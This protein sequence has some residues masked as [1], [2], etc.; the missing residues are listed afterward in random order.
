MIR[1]RFG[2]VG[3]FAVAALVAAL[4]G[5]S[6]SGSSYLPTGTSLTPAPAGAAGSAA[7]LPPGAASTSS[8][9]AA[10]ADAALRSLAP[11]G[12]TTAL[13]AVPRAVS[14]QSPAAASLAPLATSSSHDLKVMTFNL[15]VATA[16][17]LWNTWDFRRGQVVERIRSFDPDLLG[18]QE[19]LNGME[20][21]L[22]QELP[23]YTFFGVG[24]NDGKHSGEFCGVFYKTSRFEKLAGGTFWLSNH[25]EKVGSKAWG[26]WFPRIV[27]WVELRPRE[28]GQ[29]FYWFNT[30]FA[31]F[32][33]RAR[34]E[35]AKLLQA[36]MT[37]ISTGLPCVL[38][39]DFN[40]NAGIDVAAYR[41]LTSS[42]NVTRLVDAFRAAHPARTRDEGTRHDFNGHKDGDRIDWILTSP[43]FQTVSCY[44]DRTRGLLGY[45]SDHFPVMATLRMTPAASPAAPPVYPVARTG[46]RVATAQ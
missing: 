8:P 34:A 14:G 21:Y 18:T 35:S 30:H 5:C 3:G 31:A 28:G 41:T 40:A 2:T 39:G 26:S 25:P 29:P 33:G 36:R 17:D 16:F 13:P 24:R 12:S 44:I 1:C 23:E 45:P 10:V 27:T 20:D 37:A 19:G 38:T 46:G 11:A 22:K 15:R 6:S 4:A 43:A 42:Y 32:S 9:S 7:I